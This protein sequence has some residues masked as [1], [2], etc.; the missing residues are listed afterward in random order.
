MPFMC[1]FQSI[2]QTEALNF[3]DILRLVIL[4]STVFA[5][6]EIRKWLRRRKTVYTNNYSYGV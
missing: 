2:F 5:V 1:L 6:D 4:T 3:G